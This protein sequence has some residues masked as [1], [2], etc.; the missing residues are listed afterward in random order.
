VAASN[1]DPQRIDGLAGSVERG[2]LGTGSKSERE[3]VWLETAQ[4]RFVLRHKEGPAFGD[5]SLEQYVGKHVKCDGFI[6]GY[7]LLAEQIKIVPL[8]KSATAQ[9]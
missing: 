9:D 5:L 2:R 7:T 1:D 8:K 3:A 6:V 4:G